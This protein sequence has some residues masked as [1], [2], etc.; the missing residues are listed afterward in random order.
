MKKKIKQIFALLFLILLSF[1]TRFYRLDFPPNVVFDEAHFGLYATKYLSHQYY[2]D[3]HPPLGKLIFGLVAFLSKAE[4]GFDFEKSKSYGDFNFL[5]LRAIVAFFGVFLIILIYFLVKE[6]GF[7]EKTAFFSAFFMIFDNA[8]L[9][10]SRLI[11]MDI[12]LLFF[13]FLSLYLYLL[14]KKTTPF[15]RRWWILNFFLGISLGAAIS[16]K[17]IGLGILFLLWLWEIFEERVFSKEKKE[18][19]VKIGLWAIL[20]LFLFFLFFL[21]HFS[22]LWEN[23]SKNCGFVLE[24]EIMR[25]KA[26][27]ISF[28]LLLNTL[29]EG[30][31]FQKIFREIK[32][33]MWS[34]L[35]GQRWVFE[36][37]FYLWPL[38]FQPFPY[39][40]TFLDEKWILIV[41]LGNPF[42]WWGSFFGILV[43][44]YLLIRNLIV[45][46]KKN[47]PPTFYSPN[48]RL[49]FLGFIIFWVSFLI[50][51][52]FLL[53][54]HY[55]TA[56]VF[57]II[58]FSNL[59]GELF[60]KIPRYSNILFF[61]TLIFCFLSFLFF[62]PL[63][64]GFPI[65]KTHFLVKKWL[66]LFTVWMK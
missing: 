46:F 14:I 32:M 61:G 5:P 9:L 38:M 45:K 66:P 8:L 6:L 42:V 12:F 31:I 36:S 50:I 62:S 41:F 20:P 48:L 59:I 1:F 64:Y 56:L 35:S 23:C 54:Y 52:R 55:L 40:H 34:N 43:Y 28:Y 63:T 29:P 4:P 25:A 30:N 27:G 17:L 10:Q 60:Q 22:L 26:E 11:L 57:A 39:F 51:P 33:I 24:G 16:I 15:S 18:L 37:P 44:L 2:F 21:I 19:F 65:S 13:I 58:I 7:S 47:L 49:L 3:V 53:L